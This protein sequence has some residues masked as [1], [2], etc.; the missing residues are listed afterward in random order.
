MIGLAPVRATSYSP[1]ITRPSSKTGYVSSITALSF[2]VLSRQAHSVRN[3]PSRALSST[4]FP[5]SRIRHF[6]RVALGGNE[7]VVET[8]AGREHK[9]QRVRSGTIYSDSQAAGSLLSQGIENV[10]LGDGDEA[11]GCKPELRG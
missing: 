11:V 5:T 10:R 9:P 8:G 7:V 6:G 2:H 1:C 4:V 3:P